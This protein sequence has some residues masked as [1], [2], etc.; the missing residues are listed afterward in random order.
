MTNRPVGVYANGF[1]EMPLGWRGREGDPL[2]PARTDMGTD[3][4][5]QIVLEWVDAGADIVGGC[6]EIGPDHIARI[7]QV[8]PEATVA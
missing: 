7:R 6:C 3:R 4:Y 1:R 8:L 5:A 2:P